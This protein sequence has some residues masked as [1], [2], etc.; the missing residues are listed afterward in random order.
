LILIISSLYQYDAF[1][2]I[3][4]TARSSSTAVVKVAFGW[5][6]Q[7]TSSIS[8]SSSPSSSLQLRAHGNNKNDD[9]HAGQYKINIKYSSGTFSNIGDVGTSSSSSSSSSSSIGDSDSKHSKRSVNRFSYNNYGNRTNGGRRHHHHP[10]TSSYTS[11]PQSPQ[12]PRSFTWK[13]DQNLNKNKGGSGWDRNE[14]GRGYTMKQQQEQH[15]F[16]DRQQTYLRQA[17]DGILQTTPGS[18]SKGKWHELVSL[19]KAWSKYAKIDHD[20]PVMIERLLKRLVDERMAGNEEAIVDIHMYNMLLDAWCC[21]AFFQTKRNRHQ[22]Q[23]QPQPQQFSRGPSSSSNTKGARTAIIPNLASQRAREI[24]VLLQENYETAIR[25]AEERQQQQ[26]QGNATTELKKVLPSLMTAFI[27]PNEDSFSMVFDVV[28]KVEGLTAARRVLAWM[29]YIYKMGRND[30]AQPGK[31]YYIRILDAYANSRSTNAG[32]LAEGFIRHMNMTGIQPDTVCYNI[33]IKAWTKSQRG[34]ESA[35]HAERILDEMTVPK[36]LITYSTVISA[37]GSSGMQ[38]HAVARAERLLRAI[39]ETP[40]LEPNTIV[41]NTVMS[42]WVKSKNPQAANRTGEMLE[43][44]ESSKYAPADLISYNTHLHALSIHAD[45][46]LGDAQRATDLL[47]SLEDRY[48]RGLIPFRPNLFS[49]NIVLDAWARSM[50]YDAAWSAVKVLRNLIDYDKYNSNTGNKPGLQQQRPQPDTYSFNQVLTAL[51]RSTKPGAAHL[52][53]QLLTY[54]DVA[55]KIRSLKNVKADVVSYT[56]VIIA[57]ARS[58]EP[59]AAEKGERLFDRLKQEYHSSGKTYMKPNRFVYNSLIDAWAKSGKGTLGAR[60]A[61][62][63]LKEMDEICALSGDTSIAPDVVTYNSVVNSWA[64]SGTRCCGNKAEEYLDR[65]WQLYQ[66]QGEIKPNDKTFNTVINA[67]S[68]SQNEG[69]AQKALRILRRMDKLYRSGYKEARPNAFTYTSVLNAAAFPATSTDQRTKRKALD[70]A[71]F[72]L[73]ELQASRYGQPNE[74]TYCTFLKA[75]SNLLCENDTTLREVIQETF[76]QCR[77]DG[78]VGDMFLKHLRE[79]APMDLY[80]ELLADVLSGA[81]DDDADDDDVVNSDDEVCML[82]LPPAWYCNVR[83]KRPWL[84]QKTQSSAAAI[85]ATRQSTRVGKEKFTP[86]N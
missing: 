9:K 67:V 77:E 68:K 44:M 82:D 8:L 78:Q 48:R 57:L 31:K 71:I 60:K 74:I 50:D 47:T 37:W 35:E 83:N 2:N 58:G 64:R 33:A 73:Q 46:R 4:S 19:M 7:S 1:V 65:M 43:Y 56:L 21:D 61:E 30:L 34:R 69:K 62:A 25:A 45:R 86:G 24:L 3:I 17:T 36:D 22:L 29:E 80:Q 53:E 79:A 26:V 84:Q 55:Y 70:T 11:S 76:H 15:S 10:Q 85:A 28:L 66:S 14:D 18:L 27:Q 5:T 59:D 42:T 49:Y 12:Q 38:S 16:Q 81:S 63:L 13:Y 23:Q 20:T 72:T 41:L 6:I 32:P 51:S 39:E 40:H 75:C 52:A 54:M